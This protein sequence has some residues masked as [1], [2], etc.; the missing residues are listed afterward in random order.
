MAAKFRDDRATDLF[1]NPVR[2]ATGQPG[3]PSLQITDC[4]RDMVE[5]A[6]ARGWSNQRIA[7]AMGISPAS[8]KRHFRAALRQRDVA[9]DKL[10]LAAN[11][12]LMRAAV[13]DGN[14][15]AMKQ[16]REMLDRDALTRQKVRIERQQQEQREA[17]IGVGKKEAAQIAAE[18]A[19]TE[20][21]GWGNLLNPDRLN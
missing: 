9:R 8:L 1:G 3:R 7:N 5:A 11:A 10:E 2:D 18:D 16:L 13:I 4:D 20:S 21:D 15:T 14:M 17:G 19:A 12:T 6:L